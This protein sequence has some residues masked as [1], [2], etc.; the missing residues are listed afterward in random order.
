VTAGTA[1]RDQTLAR[2]DRIRAPE[3]FR[4]WFFS[5]LE[6]RSASNRLN[7]ENGGIG[8]KLLRYPA[9]LSALINVKPQGAIGDAALSSLIVGGALLSTQEGIQSYKRTIK[10]CGAIPIVPEARKRRGLDVLLLRHVAF[11]GCA[12][13][14]PVFAQSG[15]RIFEKFLCRAVIALFPRQVSA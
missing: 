2:F 3:Y 9:H 7:L 1:Q 13:R 6:Q 14:L 11:A 12:F 4:Q 10:V 8:M 5:A 15:P